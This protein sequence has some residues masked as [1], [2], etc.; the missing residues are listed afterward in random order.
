VKDGTVQ[1][2]ENFDTSILSSIYDLVRVARDVVNS[3]SQYCHFEYNGYMLLYPKYDIRRI[4]YDD[5][6]IYRVI[7]R[8]S[9]EEFKF[10]TRSCAMPPGI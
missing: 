1:N 3:E 4:D 10:A 5:S 2:F 6:K 7:D 8:K 9:G